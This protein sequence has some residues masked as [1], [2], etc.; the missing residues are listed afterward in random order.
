[1]ATHHATLIVQP[2]LVLAVAINTL[3]LLNGT[4]SNS[5]VLIIKRLT[6]F[7]TFAIIAALLV[8]WPF[9]RWG[10]DQTIQTQIDHLSRHNFFRDPRGFAVFFF[11]LYGPLIFIIPFLFRRWSPHF[12]GLLISFVVLFV[13]GLGGMIVSFIFRSN[14]DDIDY[15]VPAQEVHE[16]ESAYFQRIGSQA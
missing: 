6:I 7:G 14:N 11:P 3:V 12:A 1:M 15:Y 2:F 10:M 16:T 9:W 5:F 8:I 4:Q 13:L